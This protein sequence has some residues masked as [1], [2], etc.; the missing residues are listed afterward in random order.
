M[1]SE[2]EEEDEQD[3]F[4]VVNNPA[5]DLQEENYIR[6]R[7]HCRP[8]AYLHE[9]VTNM[10]DL[11]QVYAPLKRLIVQHVTLYQYAKLRAFDKVV[12]IC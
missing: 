12:M 2:D 7:R 1:Q 11:P 8:P 4:H 6:P 5:V 9:Y 3:N 10:E